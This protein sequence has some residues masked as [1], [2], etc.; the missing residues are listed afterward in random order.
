MAG[1]SIQYFMKEGLGLTATTMA[2]IASA[3]SLAWWIKPGFGLLSDMVPLWGYRRKSY[4]YLCNIL[5]VILWLCLAGMAFGGTL[6][7]FWPIA[8]ISFFMAFN[9]AITD[10]VADGLMV[11]TG[12]ETDNTGRFQAIQWG[13]IRLAAMLTAVLGSVLALWA[14]PDN[15]KASFEITQ[16]VYSRLGI[17]FLFAALFP[18]VNIIATYYL[19]EEDKIK[20]DK[21]KFA[22]IKA[23]I[24]KALKMKRLWVLAICIF[25]LSFSPGWGTPF[26]YYMR[27]HCGKT[28][29]QM[30]KM[31]LAY[32]STLESGLGIIG[33]VAYWKYCRKV[34]I[35][36]L[37]YLSII[38]GSI[39]SIC[40]LWISGIKSLV[41]M[42][43]L[44]GPI[45]AFISLAYFDLV[46]KNCPNLAEGFV[47]AGFMSIMNVASSASSA[48]GGWMYELLEKGGA[49][50]EWGWSLT[51]WL[52][53]FGVSPHMV[54]LRPLIIIST[55]FTL[56]TIIFIP[57]LKLDKK[58][59]MQYDE[60]K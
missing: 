39:A 51:G 47:F 45:F 16:T 3:T 46:A 49:W 57:M 1:T 18:L 59:E 43:V 17:I 53:K 41:L 21:K 19:T 4:V 28:G 7:T 34:K 29:G 40:Y 10:V 2:Y 33:C 35:K 8:I 58:G 6:T 56:V 48:M 25:G 11:Q 9:F 54:G 13:T 52:T 36:N 23:G 50:H 5:S 22:E 42:S 20:L 32:L 12:K 24:K 38:L 44:F 15:G 27:D 26:F 60:N 30:G 31:T 37:L 55:L 14:M